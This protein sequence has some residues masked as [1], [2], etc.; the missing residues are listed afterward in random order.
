MDLYQFQ[1]ISVKIRDFCQFRFQFKDF[2]KKQ[3]LFLTKTS[4]ATNLF[5]VEHFKHSKSP[6]TS[7]ICQKPI[8][9][10]VGHSG[11]FRGQPKKFKNLYEYKLH[12]TKLTSLEFCETL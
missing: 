3:H 10:F 8:L 12:E 5:L 7:K 4:C 11:V 1:S 2:L 9:S 6:I